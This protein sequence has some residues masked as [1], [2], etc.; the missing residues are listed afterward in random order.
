[1]K[2]TQRAGTSRAAGQYLL[3]H[4]QHLQD[5][6]EQ[7]NAGVLLLAPLYQVLQDGHGHAQQQIPALCGAGGGVGP[8]V[9]THRS[10]H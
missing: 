9:G 3:G 8:A 2:P 1:M 6:A 7:L 4:V 5:G 10:P